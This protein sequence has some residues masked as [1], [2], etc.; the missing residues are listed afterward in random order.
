V[1]IEVGEP[2]RLVN[3]Q[4]ENAVPRAQAEHRGRS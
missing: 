2:A 3:D 4:N 1:D